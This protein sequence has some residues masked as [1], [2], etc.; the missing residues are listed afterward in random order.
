GGIAEDGAPG[1]LID[2]PPTPRLKDFLK[3]VG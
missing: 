3:H 2:N 1:E